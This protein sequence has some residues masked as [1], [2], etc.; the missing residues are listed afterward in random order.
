MWPRE[1]RLQVSISYVN[2]KRVESLY[3]NT[4]LSRYLNKG[5]PN[6][7]RPRE[8]V[9]EQQTLSV[10]SFYLR[11]THLYNGT[12]AMSSGVK[13]LGVEAQRQGDCIFTHA[14]IGFF[15]IYIFFCKVGCIG[16]DLWAVEVA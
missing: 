5:V 4:T 11:G 13:R 2:I 3:T 12:E 1:I 14:S 10:I 16:L 9:F 8:L 7:Y 15:F 6:P